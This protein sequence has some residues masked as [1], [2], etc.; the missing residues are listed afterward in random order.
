MKQDLTCIFLSA[1]VNSIGTLQYEIPCSMKLIKYPIHFMLNSFLSLSFYFR[2]HKSFRNIMKETN[3]FSSGEPQKIWKNWKVKGRGKARRLNGREKLKSEK[4]TL[5]GGTC[6]WTIC[7]SRGEKIVLTPRN[8]VPQLN[9]Y[10][11]EVK[12]HKCDSESINFVKC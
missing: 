9:F 3:R 1:R 4:A 2:I 6:C 12:S 7:G 11:R 5:V 8:L 10:V